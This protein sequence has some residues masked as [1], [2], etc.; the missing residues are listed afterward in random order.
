MWYIDPDGINFLLRDYFCQE[1]NGCSWKYPKQLQEKLE[2]RDADGLASLFVSKGLVIYNP[3]AGGWSNSKLHN[4]NFEPP[5]QG[6]KIL[7]DPPH[8][9]DE[10]F[11]TPLNVKE[12]LIIKQLRNFSTPLKRNL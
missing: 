9:K 3:A 5:S 2:R 6:K 12:P 8:M 1:C 7:F 11:V 10:I 4:K